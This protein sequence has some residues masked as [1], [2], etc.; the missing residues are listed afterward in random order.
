MREMSQA[1]WTAF[2]RHGT[3]TG[4]LALVLPSGRPTVTPVWFVL[5]DDGVLRF[6]TDTD[7]AKARSLRADPR[8]CILVDLEEPPYAFVRL[9]VVTSMV[10]DLAAVR[11]LAT[12]I[13]RRYMGEDRAEEYGERNGVPGEIIVECVITRVVAQHDVSG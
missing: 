2:L 3:R 4:K 9:D 1:E 5:D 12:R 11:A 6:E 10:D 8:A 13:G 7:S